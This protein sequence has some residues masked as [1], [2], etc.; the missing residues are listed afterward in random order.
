MSYDEEIYEL[1]DRYLSGNASQAEKV[2]MNERFMLDQE[3]KDEFEFY[4]IGRDLI[5]ENR[6]QKTSEAINRLRETETGKTPGNTIVLTVTAILLLSVAG[7]ATYFIKS[8]NRAS[9]SQKV[10]VT[11][12]SLGEEKTKDIITFSQN[13]SPE[14]FVTKLPVPKATFQQNE[15][16]DQDQLTAQG[17]SNTSQTEQSSEENTQTL[18]AAD[19]LVNEPAAANALQ[20]ADPCAAVSITARLSAIPTCAGKSEGEIDIT[21]VKGGTKPYTFQI[22]NSVFSEYQITNL[23]AGKY[24]VKVTDENGCQGDLGTAAVGEKNCYESQD[25]SFNPFDGETLKIPSV[26]EKGG[27]LKIL[28]R[29]GLT[30]YRLQFASGSNLIWDGVSSHDGNVTEGFYIY[31][32]EYTDRSA[33]NGTITIVR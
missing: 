24:S 16:T 10:I 4:R 7:I 1:F 11:D 30:C 18:P 22:G 29:S 5:I 27:I 15:N 32:I 28:T 12:T 19:R 6:L 33:E 20:P 23:R 3:F 17:E 14:P 13:S 21:S 2:L 9:I 25:L 26:R 8:K 31:I